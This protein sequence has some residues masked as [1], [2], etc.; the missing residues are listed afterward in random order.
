MLLRL[1]YLALT[2]VFTLIRL[3]PVTDS[4]KNVEIL[5]L[6]HQLAILQR[7]I[8]KPRLTPHDRAFLAALLHRLPKPKLRQLH[9]IVSPDTVLRWHRDLLRR[10]HAKQSRPKQPGRPPTVRS[11]QTLVLRMAR[12]N[13]SW[14]Y[15]RA[16]GELAGLGIQ[17]AASTVWEILKT[18]GI[19][20]APRR[21]HQTWATFL[22]GQAQAILAADFFETRTL[23]GARLYVFA[24]IE[25][26]TRRVRVLGATAHPTA[27]WTTQ[28]AR[29]LVMDLHDAGTTVKHLIRDRDSK[30]AAAFDA[31]LE[32][33]G[34]AITK[35]GV[36]V[37]RMN[38]IMERWV[39]SCR[40]ELLDRTLIVNRAHLLHALHEYETF[41]N[42]H[43]TRRALH[44]AAPLRPLPQPITAPD[45]LDH[46]DIRRR[47]RL[48]GILHEY[49]HAA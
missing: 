35:T 39:H 8:D 3:I 33:E 2:S 18:N 22:R 25:H 11:I 26:A 21:D 7:Q 9:L 17:V 30:Y 19:E 1:P 23:T 43:R 5:T 13:T 14:G 16:H 31:V 41:Y 36:R 48:G 6:R 20:P 32:D 38:A 28:L 34:I 44:A 46:L 45:R 40:A 49:E 12:E 27:T 15:R 29:N 42:Q 24:V 37:P 10:H 47:D 4:D